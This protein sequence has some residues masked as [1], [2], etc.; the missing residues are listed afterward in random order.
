MTSRGI[1][2]LSAMLAGFAFFAATASAAT[3]SVNT[4]ADGVNPDANCTIR[5][6]LNAA[7]TN[8]AANGC[9][10]GESG[11]VDTVSL[12]ASGTYILDGAAGEELN[13]TG[14][15]DVLASPGPDAGLIIKGDPGP[16]ASDT[17]DK[18]EPSG[19]DRVLEI[20]S[21]G[22]VTLDTVT[23]QGGNLAFSPTSSG[24]GILSQVGLTIV[25]SVIRANQSG[26][27]GG[28]ILALGPLTITDSLVGGSTGLDGNRSRVGGGV[29]AH[30][31]L[32]MLRTLIQN[33]VATIAPNGGAFDLSVGGGLAASTGTATIT[34]STFL[35]NAAT[36]TETIDGVQAGAVSIENGNATIS[37][38]TISGNSLNGGTN[39]SAAGIRF[40]G[41]ST[42]PTA[43]I[44]NSTLSG[45]TVGAGPGS[46][47]TSAI[48]AQTG[49]LALTQSTI[50]GNTSP[51]NIAIVGGTAI[52]ARG[53]LINQGADP[54]FQPLTADS[55][56]ADAG[57]DCVGTTNDTDIEN[58]AALDLGGLLSN[59]GP[60]S[61]HAIG[62]AGT[63]LLDKVPAADCLDAAGGSPLLVDQRGAERPTG[64]ACDIGA[65]ERVTCNG[66]VPN[67]LGGP[68]ND[69]LTGFNV[70]PDTMVGSAGNDTMDGLT[71]GDN[72]CGGSGNDT[73]TGGSGLDLIFGET[74]NDTIHALD[75]AADT[76]DCG[77]GTDS[78]DADAGLDTVVACE[79]DVNA[80][81]VDPVNPPVKK[82]KCKK[83][84]KL[85][86]GK[87]VKKK[88][89]KKK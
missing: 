16:S 76:I 43:T 59:G 52:T 38:T 3:I 37:G 88:R 86:K 36:A 48:L 15:L 34:D 12:D 78:Y 73:L 44:R 8:T 70:F 55:Y 68:G 42:P 58:A 71:V 22:P 19:L 49:T 20:H 45:N 5:E 29:S 13:A 53:T 21:G 75:G 50:T 14:D 6:A 23:I 25:R 69:T 7:R 47:S 67:V 4:T 85:K 60:T 26:G 39:A 33:N 79:T 11:A 80:P 84:R 62:P 46:R 72:I 63:D 40:A 57:T 51:D 54:C 28:G 18:I 9:T 74:G 32:T 87:C 30:G 27:G 65:Y 83:G 1:W 64:S 81:P 24:G 89:K 17:E 82:K 2:T 41:G 35:G 77:P 31:G 56:N 66:T 10:T 61:T